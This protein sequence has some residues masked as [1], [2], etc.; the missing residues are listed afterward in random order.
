MRLLEVGCSAGLN[1]RWGRFPWTRGAEAVEVIERRGCDLN[2]ID[3]TLEES[4]LTL[5]SFIWADQ[6]ERF[7][8]LSVALDVAARFPAQLD[9]S[10][11][12]PWVREQLKT[13]SPGAA[14]VVFHSVLT[15]YLN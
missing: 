7:G 14:T 4:R 8:Q 2:P 13:P 15:P 11:A 3:P 9:R 12:A 10:D 6:T 1:L 5:L